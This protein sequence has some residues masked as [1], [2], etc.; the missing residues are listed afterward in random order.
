MSE[1]NEKLDGN[2]ILW[3]Q[4]REYGWDD[5]LIQTIID[6]CDT[7]KDDCDTEEGRMRQAQRAVQKMIFDA[8]I[9]AEY[10]EKTKELVPIDLAVEMKKQDFPTSWDE[11]KE[12]YNIHLITDKETGRILNNDVQE[13]RSPGDIRKV[14]RTKRKNV[15]ISLTD[16]LLKRFDMVLPENTI[17]IRSDEDILPLEKIMAHTKPKTDWTFNLLDK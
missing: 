5:Q 15:T 16:Y 13:Y 3:T 10:K 6:N 14:W 8:E 1:H 12:K 11:I 7:E 9:Q 17:M 2:E 4:L